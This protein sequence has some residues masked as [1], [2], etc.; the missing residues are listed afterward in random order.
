MTD[1]GLTR[2]TL[3]ECSLNL[4]VWN[5]LNFLQ[6]FELGIK[7]YSDGSCS[8]PL[9]PTHVSAYCFGVPLAFRV[10]SPGQPQFVFLLPADCGG[11]GSESR[12]AHRLR[13]PIARVHVEGAAVGLAVSACDAGRR[14]V[15]ARGA[16]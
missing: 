15:A 8:P 5:S 6:G 1:G 3:L 11:A 14:G 2:L 13:I 4:S 10:P 16:G 7:R 12:V 9:N